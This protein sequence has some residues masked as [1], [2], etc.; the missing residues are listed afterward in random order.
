MSTFIFIDNCE[1]EVTSTTS[2]VKDNHNHGMHVYIVLDK[3]T[4]ILFAVTSF[5][6]AIIAG[7]IVGSIFVIILIIVVATLAMIYC[8]TSQ[9]MGVEVVSC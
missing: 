9:G 8:I 5:I 6:A 2:E 4:V 7:S 3:L 1:L